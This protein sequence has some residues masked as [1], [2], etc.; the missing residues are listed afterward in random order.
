M[1]KDIKDGRLSRFALP[2]LAAALRAQGGEA[3]AANSAATWM[4]QSAY[5]AAVLLLEFPKL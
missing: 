4:C 1:T 3:F 5:E 2:I